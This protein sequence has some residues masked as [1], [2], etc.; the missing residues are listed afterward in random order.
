MS[1]QSGNGKQEPQTNPIY[2]ALGNSYSYSYYIFYNIN[3]YIYFKV[4]L[5]LR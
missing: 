2:G 1:Y 5:I 3:Q 4:L